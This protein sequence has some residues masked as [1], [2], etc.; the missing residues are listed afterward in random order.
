[1]KENERK[2]IKK[3]KKIRFNK[4]MVFVRMFLKSNVIFV[5][6]IFGSKIH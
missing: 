5:P 4:K 1:M 6:I 3:V 2:N